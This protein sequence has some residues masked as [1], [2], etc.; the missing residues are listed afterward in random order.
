MIIGKAAQKKLL[1]IENEKCLGGID[2]FLAEIRA[3]KVI[4]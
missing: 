2:F 4:D 3:D 1:W